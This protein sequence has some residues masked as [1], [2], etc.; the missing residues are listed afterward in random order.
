MGALAQTKGARRNLLLGAWERT[1]TFNV[2]KN[3]MGT[4]Y[5]VT[6]AAANENGAVFYDDVHP[7]LP[8]RYY[9]AGLYQADGSTLVS[10]ATAQRALKLI[11]APVVWI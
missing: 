1:G 11:V 10:Q 3:T 7:F 4:P 9:K 8:F 5:A 2:I 6:I